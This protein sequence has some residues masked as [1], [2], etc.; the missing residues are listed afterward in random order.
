M[1]TFNFISCICLLITNISNA[2]VAEHVNLL[3]NWY[4][5]T[6]IGSAEYDNVYNEIWG[7]V[8]DDR[9][10][11]II[12]SSYGTHFFDVTIP[13]FSFEVA[14]VKGRVIGSQIIHRDYHDYNGYL[15]AVCDEGV[16]SLQII[17]ISTLPDSVSLV[18]DSSELFER[19]QNIFI[20]T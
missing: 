11:A 15:Y 20:D 9:E 5:D 16:S 7:V 19:S 14:V 1:K 13:E 12:G 4:E 18:Y 6:L 10:Y 2:Q 3:F 17:D 8:V